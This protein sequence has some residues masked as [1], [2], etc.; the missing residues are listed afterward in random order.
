MAEDLTSHSIE[1]LRTKLKSAQA[2]QRTVA[3]I[4]AVIV[5]AWVVL[6]FWRTN[7]PVFIS[8][9]AMGVFAVAV[10]S[11]APRALKTEIARRNSAA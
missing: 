6:G 2:I 4:F 10:T 7:T 5:L 3:G 1:T 9:L 8:T 11:I